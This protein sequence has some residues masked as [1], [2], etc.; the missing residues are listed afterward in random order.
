M[1]ALNTTLFELINA[2]VAP[3]GAVLAAALFLADK[4]I[5][6]VAAALVWGWARAGS[7][8]R[9]KLFAVG[10]TAVLGLA[11][12]LTIAA[13][14]QNPRPFAL[15]VGNQFLPHAPDGS[16]PSD[17]ATILFS[18]A[19]GL[20][21]ARAAS[22]WSWLALIVAIAVAWSRIYVGVH[23]PM[24]M[25][26][27]VVVAFWAASVARLVIGSGPGRALCAAVLRLYD[28]A[29]NLARIPRRISPRSHDAD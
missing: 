17:H 18:V 11:I 2:P 20:F 9:T 6:L 28:G 19:F 3:D 25:A 29:L 15:G 10:L 26:G 12:N 24:D 27:S 14:W 16:F 5:F 7:R 13:F 22:L 21:A 1:Y 8:T 23:W 4:V